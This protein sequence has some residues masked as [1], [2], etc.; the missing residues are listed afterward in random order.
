MISGQF[1]LLVDVLLLPSVGIL[2]FTGILYSLLTPLCLVYCIGDGPDPHVQIL[3]ID[4]KAVE[5]PVG[6]AHAHCATRLLGDARQY[7]T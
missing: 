5:A 4:R 7:F 1:R 6:R 3:L 2:G